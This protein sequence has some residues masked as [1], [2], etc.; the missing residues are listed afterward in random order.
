MHC[1]WLDAMAPKP[2]ASSVDVAEEARG[3]PDVSTTGQAAPTSRMDAARPEETPLAPADCI[4]RRCWLLLPM[5]RKE[6]EIGC[7]A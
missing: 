6:S 5:A 3:R 2:A 7:R 4:K 1:S